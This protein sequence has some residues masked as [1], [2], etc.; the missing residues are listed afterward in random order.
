MA[1]AVVV[2][3][4]AAPPDCTPG[5]EVATQIPSVDGT[6]HPIV[7]KCRAEAFHRRFPAIRPT[8][9]CS[10]AVD[11]DTLDFPMNHR[12]RRPDSWSE[13]QVEVVAATD[14]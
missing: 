9:C 8:A 1:V 6:L 11:V 14:G 3:A 13:Q 10:G 5:T 7:H 2:A 12:L 4:V